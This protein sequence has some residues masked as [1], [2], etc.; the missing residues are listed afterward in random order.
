MLIFFNTSPLEWPNACSKRTNK[1]SA[2]ETGF[3]SSDS[4][5]K[6]EW[7]NGDSNSRAPPFDPRCSLS[8][9][10][11]KRSKNAFQSSAVAPNRTNANTSPRISK[12]IRRLLIRVDLGVSVFTH[13]T[14]HGW[15]FY[16]SHMRK[17][18][19]NTVKAWESDCEGNME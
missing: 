12:K 11:T 18:K 8:K 13:R 2:V 9:S 5:N 3:R 10:S 17:A 1:E 14:R 15:K 19:W 4:R 16:Q 6:R 7:I